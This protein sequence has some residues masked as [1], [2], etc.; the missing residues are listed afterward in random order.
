MQIDE[1]PIGNLYK[2]NISKYQ[3]KPVLEP[4]TSVNK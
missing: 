4:L 3:L 1:G 2:Y